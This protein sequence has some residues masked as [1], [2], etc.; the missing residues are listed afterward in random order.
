[1]ASLAPLSGNLGQ[2]RA[3]HLLRRTA[4]NFTKTKVDSLA[5]MTAS[6][7]ANQMLVQK[8]LWHDQPWWVDTATPTAPAQTFCLPYTTALPTSDFIFI[9]YVMGWWAHEAFRDTGIGHKMEL[10]LHQNSIVN[11]NTFGTQYLFDYMQLLR[12][13]ALG[14]YKKFATK[15]VTDNTM[16]VYL[17]NNSNSAT[18]P[19][20]NFAR[21]FFE[22]FTIGKGPEIAPGNYT[23]YTEDDIVAA[24]RLL[25]GFRVTYRS[26]YAANLDPDTGILRGYAKISSHDKNPKAFS[27]ASVGRRKVTFIRLR[28]SASAWPR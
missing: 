14:N 23:N 21:E 15:L 10:F 2:K 9:P 16:L 28:Q 12:F 26:N 17:N 19:N 4:F 27:S 13:Y 7:A 6:A 24:A 8:P 25:T 20:E 22:L 5:A 18:N 11:A 3:A 1:M